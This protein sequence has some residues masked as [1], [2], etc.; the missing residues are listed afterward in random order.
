[1]LLLVSSGILEAVLGGEFGEVQTMDWGWRRWRERG[2]RNE[3]GVEGET[4]NRGREEPGR[5]GSQPA[6]E[7]QA[8]SPGIGTHPKG[9][10]GSQ[11]PEVAIREAKTEPAGSRRAQDTVRSVRTDS[12]IALTMEGTVSGTPAYMPPEQET[13]SEALMSMRLQSIFPSL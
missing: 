1:M 7:G 11:T 2:T 8:G 13:D 3:K 6:S 10:S 5:A 9:S 12:D 4:G